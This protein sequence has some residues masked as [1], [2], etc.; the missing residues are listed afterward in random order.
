MWHRLWRTCRCVWGGAG[1]WHVESAGRGQCRQSIPAVCV[2]A[3]FPHWVGFEVSTTGKPASITNSTVATS[4]T[5]AAAHQPCHACRR[6]HCWSPSCGPPVKRCSTCCPGARCLP[7]LAHSQHQ[8]QQRQ[9][10]R[11]SLL[12]LQQQT[13]TTAATAAARLH[14]Q[15]QRQCRPRFCPHSSCMAGRFLQR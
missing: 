4:T 2:R 14:R 10:Q 6:W 13:L 1:W 5:A 11:L 12:Q 9:P 8:Q 3:G 15:Q 7:L